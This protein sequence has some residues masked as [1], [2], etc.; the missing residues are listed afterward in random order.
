MRCVG[1]RKWRPQ[2]CMSAA[3]L[4]A[5]VRGCSHVPRAEHASPLAQLDAVG[6]FVGDRL[7]ALRE[8]RGAPP[9][10]IAAARAL[11]APRAL[12]AAAPPGGVPHAAAVA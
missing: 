1:I 7:A 3:S 10:A 6:N 5:R 8:L 9:H 12:T 11:P 4:F 2:V